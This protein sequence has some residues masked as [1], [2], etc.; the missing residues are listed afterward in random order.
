MKYREDCIFDGNIEHFSYEAGGMHV[1]WFDYRDF[2]HQYFLSHAHEDHYVF[3]DKGGPKGVLTK[4]FISKLKKTPNV[5]IYSTEETRDIVLNRNKDP[6]L[7]IEELKRH[8]ETLK[9]DIETELRLIDKTGKVSKK[10]INVKAIP[11]NHIPGAVMFLFEDLDMDKRALYTGDFRYDVDEKNEEM[12][13]LRD[14]VVNYDKVID[15]LYVD[16]TCLDLGRLYHPDQNKFPSRPQVVQEVIK[17]VEER[18]P[19]SI[20]IDVSPLG[21]E[22]IVVSIAEHLNVSAD[23][24]YVDSDSVNDATK[25]LLTEIKVPSISPYSNDGPSIHI[26]SGNMFNVA[27]KGKGDCCKCKKDTLRI[28]GTL[29]WVFKNENYNKTY[30]DK[31]CNHRYD[32]LAR[33][34]RDFWQVLYSHHSSDYELRQFLSYLQFIKIFPISEPFSRDAWDMIC[35]KVSEYTDTDSSSVETDY[36]SSDSEEAAEDRHEIIM[37]SLYFTLESKSLQCPSDYT[38]NVLWFFEEGRGDNSDTSRNGLQVFKKLFRCQN[39]IIASISRHKKPIDM[40]TIQCVEKFSFRYLKNFVAKIK[41]KRKTAESVLLF[42]SN[43]T[44]KNT[45]II[46]KIVNSEY[47]ED[48]RL[49]YVDL[50]DIPEFRDSNSLETEIIIGTLRNLARNSDKVMHHSDW[51]VPYDYSVRKRE[52]DLRSLNRQREVQPDVTTEVDEDGGE[53]NVRHCKTLKGN[54]PE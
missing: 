33:E 28:R 46:K 15:Y 9:V 11:A 53:R 13:R 22:S 5:K 3:R 45:E 6:D 36:E 1:D 14:F 23:S 41:R 39:D 44:N 7:D 19:R 2:K 35:E 21:S 34:D 47:R 8:F 40:I 10:K 27:V 24:I 48:P 32:G 18:K 20:H 16:I 4:R 37:K 51:P 52:Y 26:Y 42:Y 31:W 43:T 50:I 17:I 49:N 38:L 29:H 25:Y 30:L 54:I 12:R